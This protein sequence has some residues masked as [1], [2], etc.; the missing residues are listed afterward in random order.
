[1][2]TVSIFHATPPDFMASQP[3]GTKYTHV[4]D[5]ETDDLEVAFERTN[6]I[7]NGWWENK[8]VAPTFPERGC[9]STSVG[10]LAVLNGVT[11]RC[12]ITGWEEIVVAPK[13]G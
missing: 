11:Y 8:G 9:R 12:A 4:A 7:D 5:V 6:S 13:E 1:M 3:P 10:D 2:P